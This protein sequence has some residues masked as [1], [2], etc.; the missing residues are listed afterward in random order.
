MG[1]ERRTMIKDRLERDN[2]GIVRRATLVNTRDIEPCPSTCSVSPSSMKLSG[3]SSS[4]AMVTVTTV[5]SAMG[6][7]ANWFS[8]GGTTLDWRTAW[9]GTLG[10]A[11][12]ASWLGF[13]RERRHRVAPYAYGFLLLFCAIIMPACGNGISGGGTTAARSY[14][15]T[16]TGTFTSGADTL[17]HTTKLT[18]IVQ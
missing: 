14:T 7:A 18:L 16:V 13:G 17:A 11:M 1:G 8:A 15:L 12:L 3:T 6:D 4:T 9:S 10:L 5:G 2:W